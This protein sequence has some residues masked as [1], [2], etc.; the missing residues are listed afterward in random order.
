MICKFI[1][2]L[3]GSVLVNG[4][5]CISIKCH[6]KGDVNVRKFMQTDEEKNS[7]YGRVCLLSSREQLIEVY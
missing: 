2:T 4:S 5:F 6:Y 1:H 7:A 3:Y